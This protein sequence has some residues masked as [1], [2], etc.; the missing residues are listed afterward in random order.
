MN[1]IQV[2]MYWNMTV[3]RFFVKF[4]SG[5]PNEIATLL[6]ISKEK[7]KFLNISDFLSTGRIL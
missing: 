5:F 2:T 3:E 4:E 6:D 1:L 7:I